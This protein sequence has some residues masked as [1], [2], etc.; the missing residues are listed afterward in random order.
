[1]IV[2]FVK[3]HVLFSKQMKNIFL[4]KRFLRRLRDFYSEGAKESKILSGTRK[5]SESLRKNGREAG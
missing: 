4:S 3:H 2:I 5:E 1:M